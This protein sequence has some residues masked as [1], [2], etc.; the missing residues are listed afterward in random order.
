MNSSHPII[1]GSV[2]GIVLA[3]SDMALKP[4]LSVGIMEWFKLFLEGA[5]VYITYKT[6]T[7]RDSSKTWELDFK[8]F[9]NSLFGGFAIWF[10]DLI[11]KPLLLD[12]GLGSRG[13]GG[14]E[15]ISFLLQGMV[16]YW[17]FAYMA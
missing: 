16:M 15:Y 8:F 5:I 11:F 4:R 9:S 14:M 12:Q 17:F 2:M 7:F 6:L 10:T 1:T 13:P 3:I